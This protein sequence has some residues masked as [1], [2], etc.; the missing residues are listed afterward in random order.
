MLFKEFSHSSAHS[1]FGYIIILSFSSGKLRCGTAEAYPRWWTDICRKSGIR[2][3]VFW[4][5]VQQDLGIGERG[6]HHIKHDLAQPLTECRGR[7]EL[8]VQ[9]IQL[10]H[11][12]NEESEAQKG[13]WCTSNEQN[14][15]ADSKL[16]SISESLYVVPIFSPG[17]DLFLIFCE[18][19]N[20]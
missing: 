4:L 18:L 3:S 2:N 5:L 17:S 20:K 13:V 14:F 1:Y 19:R 6:N 10:C 7:K 15:D 11:Y 9:Q 16:L 12:T 8:G